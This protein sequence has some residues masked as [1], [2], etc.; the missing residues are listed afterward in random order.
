MA[1]GQEGP[2]PGV[3]QALA[4]NQGAAEKIKWENDVHLRQLAKK[5]TYVPFFY[6]YLFFSAFWAFLAKGSPKTREKK[7]S[8][9][10]ETSTREMF[11]RGGI[12]SGW[13]FFDIFFFR[14]FCCV[15]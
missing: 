10:S 1:Y 11:F 15:G 4:L 2:C 6:F 5:S 8:A 3:A 14:F 12:F 7:L 9:V 13:I